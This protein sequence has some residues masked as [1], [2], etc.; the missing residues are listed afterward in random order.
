MEQNEEEDFGDIVG[1]RRLRLRY[2]V[3]GYSADRE[4]IETG[5]NSSGGIAY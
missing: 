4:S 3:Q 2:V 5:S 1:V